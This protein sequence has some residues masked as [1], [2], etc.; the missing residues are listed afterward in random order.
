V[1][2]CSFAHR[3]ALALMLLHREELRFCGNIGGKGE[4]RFR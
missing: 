2:G 4:Q 1:S 3:E